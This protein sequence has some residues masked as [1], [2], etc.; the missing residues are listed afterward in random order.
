MNSLDKIFAEQSALVDFVA[1]ESIMLLPKRFNTRLK[2][3]SATREDFIWILIR[4]GYIAC[5]RILTR[6]HHV[7]VGHRRLFHGSSI[8]TAYRTNSMKNT[9]G[10]KVGVI[11]GKRKR[12][13]EAGGVKHARRIWMEAEEGIDTGGRLAM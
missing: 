2:A 6:L 12:S 4:N 1:R 9:R 3:S 13:H 5:E 11:W 8:A 10:R 7:V